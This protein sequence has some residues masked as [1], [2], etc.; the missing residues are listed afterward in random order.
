ML[1]V[2]NRVR[3]S[4]DFSRT[5]RSGARSGR[6]NVVLYALPTGDQPS[7]IGFIVAKSVGN[8]VTRNLVKRRLREAAAQSLAL[9]PTGFDVVVRALPASASA[10]WPALSADYHSALNAC[11]AKLSQL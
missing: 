7:R 3:V 11:I 1:A 2:R 9:H 10:S 6:R 5:V 4:A 8:A